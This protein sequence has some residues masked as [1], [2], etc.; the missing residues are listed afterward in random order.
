MIASGFIAGEAIMGALLSIP[1]ALYKD[2]NILAIPIGLSDFGQ[3]LVGII[4]FM[5]SSLL[6]LKISRSKK[7]T[8]SS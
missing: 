5:I 4:V 2:S 1:F 6:F 8:I 3:D 7:N